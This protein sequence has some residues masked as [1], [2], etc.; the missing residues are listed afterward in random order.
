MFIDRIHSPLEN[1]VGFILFVVISFFHSFLDDTFVQHS[2]DVDGNHKSKYL[3][4]N[5]NPA[6]QSMMVKQF[7]VRIQMFVFLNNIICN[8]IHY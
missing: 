8:E 2:C 6:E 1:N 4:E 3:T 5:V 7:P